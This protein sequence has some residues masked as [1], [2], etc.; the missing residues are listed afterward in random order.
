M[1]NSVLER[2]FG[3]LGKV[4]IAAYI[5]VFKAELTDFTVSSFVAFLVNEGDRAFDFGLADRTGLVGLVN[6]EYA[7]G[8]AA[9]GRRVNVNQLN[10]LVV[11]VVSRLAAHKEHTQERTRC[12]AEHTHIRRRKEG[13]ADA[14]FNK[15]QL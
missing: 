14:L 4:H 6:L 1:V 7:Y 13:N 12:V 2:L 8:K 15:E 9:L 10:V 5:R 3:F 11:N